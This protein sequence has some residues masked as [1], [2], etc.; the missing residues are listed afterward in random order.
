MTV[1]KEL[2]IIV[3]IYLILNIIVGNLV[4]R[5]E[6]NS[7]GIQSYYHS[8]LPAS[9][10]ALACTGTAISGVAFIGTPGTT[11][12]QG[13]GV[14][15]MNAVGGI[16]GIILCTWLVGKPLMAMNRRLNTITLTDLLVDIFDDKRLRFICIPCLLVVSTVY[17]AVQWQSIGT[18]LNTLL[19]MDYTLA[20][21]LGVVVVAL[22]SIL[23]GNKSTAVVGAVQIMIAMIACVYLVFAALKVNGGG[24]G[25]LI[26]DVNLVKPELLQMTNSNLSFGAMMSYLIMYGIGYIG[27]PAIAVRYFQL[28]NPKM[29]P[30][31]MFF[32]VVSMFITTLVPIVALT[33]TVQ[34]AHGNIAELVTPD[35]CTPSFI[36]LFCGPYA[37]GLLVSA[38]LAAIMSTGASL[39]ISASSTLVKDMMGDWL[40]VDMSGKKGDI[41]SRLGTVA[42]IIASTLIACFPSGGILQIG[43]AAWG[44]FGAIFAPTMIMGLRWRRSTKQGAFWGMISGAAVVLIFTLLNLTG[45]YPWPLDWHIS[46][47]A[48]VVHFIVLIVVSL[49]TPTQDKN[50]MP[51]TRKELKAMLAEKSRN[52]V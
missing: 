38:C 2:W 8:S 46:V 23:G 32:G 50:F 34:V 12:M 26:N 3:I 52:I 25:K 49:L 1:T 4:G 28:Q 11:Y 17:T 35:S 6:K 48:I 22:Y 39:L 5:K 7:G 24:L 37:G 44:A 29:L 45:I 51:P 21:I 27:Q 31:T 47:I 13:I 43:F 14:W 19:G 9:I 10:V 42:V 16:L 40:H 30:K 20:V 33:M 15:S 41:Y 36:A 18:I